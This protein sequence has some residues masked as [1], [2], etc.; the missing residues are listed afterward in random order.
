MKPVTPEQLFEAVSTAI[1]GMSE[2]ECM[3]RVA[4][5]RRK[6]QAKQTPSLYQRRVQ[7]RR[8]ENHLEA[9]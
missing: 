1:D 4:L 8:P 7:V 6:R 2:F 5:Q 3:A 9:Q